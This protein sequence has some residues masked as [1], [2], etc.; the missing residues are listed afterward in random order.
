MIFEFYEQKY[1]G[2]VYFKLNPEQSTK[3]ESPVI[4]KVRIMCIYR[5]Y[6]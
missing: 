1:V 6:L 3:Q 4:N 5:I 2:K